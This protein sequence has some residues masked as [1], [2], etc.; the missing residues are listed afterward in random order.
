MFG[1]SASRLLLGG[2]MVALLAVG[3][4][5]VYP[6]DPGYGDAPY[7]AGLY[8]DGADVGYWGGGGWHRGW[9]QGWHGSW[10][11]GRAGGGMGHGGGGHR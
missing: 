8:Y 3:G 5:A 9:H 6:G 11:G 7:D 2:A 1:N 10:R 4:C